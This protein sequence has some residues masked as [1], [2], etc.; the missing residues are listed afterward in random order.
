MGFKTGLLV[1]LGAGYVMGAKA[2]RERYQE[3]QQ[4]LSRLTG[5]PQVR[6]AASLA[7]QAA[8]EKL[9]DSI[10]DRIPGIENGPD[11]GATHQ[12]S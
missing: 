5:S 4:G 3:I 7:K 10:V 9:P 8:A 1:G 12:A 2:G 11:K 6:E